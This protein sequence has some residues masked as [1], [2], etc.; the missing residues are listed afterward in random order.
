MK[1]WKRILFQREI[2]RTSGVELISSFR[3]KTLS[4]S[5]YKLTGEKLIC[6]LL[7]ESFLSGNSAAHIRGLLWDAQSCNKRKLRMVVRTPVRVWLFISV[8]MWCSS[9]Y[10]EK[11]LWFAQLGMFLFLSIIVTLLVTQLG[12]S[13]IE[14]QLENSYGIGWNVTL[15]SNKLH[16]EV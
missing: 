1:L 4:V 5:A 12:Y 15:L 6:I 3:V 11:A 10:T 16:L 9:V 13:T 14:C 7:N 2:Y 8:F